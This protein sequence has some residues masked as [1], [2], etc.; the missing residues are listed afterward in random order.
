MKTWAVRICNT[1][2]LCSLYGLSY[3]SLKHLLKPFEK[4]LGPKQGYLFT[5]NQVL[6]ILEVLGEPAEITIIYPS[7]YNPLRRIITS[8]NIKSDSSRFDPK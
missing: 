1:K 7:T 2:D 3:K 6:K 4:E 8:D 5:I